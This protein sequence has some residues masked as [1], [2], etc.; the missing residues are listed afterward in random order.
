MNDGKK[1]VRLDFKK[2]TIVYNWLNSQR[3]K[4]E[5]SR[6]TLEQL[7]KE[8]VDAVGFDVSVNTIKHM[9]QNMMDWKL[10]APRQ[11]NRSPKS[12]NLR[13]VKY[14]ALCV[15]VDEMAKTIKSLEERLEALE[16]FHTS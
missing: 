16:D 11:A 13:T 10:P 14:G 6:P 9:F 3:V 12:A 1:I 7:T 5:E 15:K 8:V 4:I 2:K